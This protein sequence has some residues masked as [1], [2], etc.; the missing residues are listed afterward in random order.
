MTL[1]LPPTTVIVQK[2]GVQQHQI[3]GVPAEGEFDLSGTTLTIPLAAGQILDVYEWFSPVPVY[4]TF[5][6]PGASVTLTMTPSIVLAFKNGVQLHPG[7]GLAVDQF[8]LS[9]TTLTTPLGAT[10]VL[11]VYEWL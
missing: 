2:S 7:S 5:L 10:D 11:D 9:G 3:V 8:A 1:T 6:G 4:E